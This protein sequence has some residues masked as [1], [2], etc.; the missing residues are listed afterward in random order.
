MPVHAFGNNSDQLA[1]P[2]VHIHTSDSAP[3]L[4]N[5]AYESVD[6]AGRSSAP[7]T[8]LPASAARSGS[9]ASSPG[10]QHP[11][12]L[13]FQVDQGNGISL[14]STL[15]GSASNASLAAPAPLPYGHPGSMLGRTGH[16]L[17]G[18]ISPRPVSRNHSRASNHDM[19][20]NADG[21]GRLPGD[22]RMQL[23]VGNVRHRFFQFCNPQDRHLRINCIASCSCRFEF[24]GKT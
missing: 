20:Y 14:P 15:P 10:G 7:A 4:A 6:P 24:D 8:G 12:G 16:P 13:S 11:G 23:F 18:R 19:L 9:S 5:G 21:H 2:Q 3:A 1:A 22:N 17:E